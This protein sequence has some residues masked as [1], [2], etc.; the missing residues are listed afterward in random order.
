V[1]ERVGGKFLPYDW[2]RRKWLTN[3]AKKEWR[4]TM[5]EKSQLLQ[6]VDNQQSG[7]E[8]FLSSGDLSEDPGSVNSED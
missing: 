5:A 4:K 6:V 3:R 7:F 1:A 8:L 2:L